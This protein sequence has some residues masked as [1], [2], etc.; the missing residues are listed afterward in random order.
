MQYTQEQINAVVTVTGAELFI[1][2]VIGNAYSEAVAIG[3]M[4]S[5][6]G[7]GLTERDI[8]HIQSLM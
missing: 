5:H 3:M 7:N 8:E 2:H 4:L 6:D 1:N